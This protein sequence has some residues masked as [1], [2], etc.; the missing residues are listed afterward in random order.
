MKLIERTAQ[1]RLFKLLRRH[2]R[3]TKR[4]IIAG[5]IVFTLLIIVYFTISLLSITQSEIALARLKNSYE[6]EKIC[7]E[8]CY[9]YRL[10]QEELVIASINRNSSKIEK[11]LEKYWFKADLNP[12][13][14]L[15]IV[16]LLALRPNQK[17]MPDYLSLYLT[18][19][20]YD[21]NVAREIIKRYDLSLGAENDLVTFLINKLNSATS[22]PDK[23][24]AL[25]ILAELDDDGEIENYL[26]ILK[27]DADDEFK[28]QV[29][30]NISNIKDKGHY[31]NAEQMTSLSSLANLETTSPKLRQ[32]IVLLIGDYC[33]LFSEACLNIL[34]EIYTNESLDAISRAFSVE[35]INRLSNQ[36]YELPL[37]S[38][39]EWSNYYN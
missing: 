29:L 33:S 11:R 36:A 39:S 24:S 35:T 17:T 4:K 15:E 38:E 2:L 3:T 14:R 23:I 7:H 20:M 27:I 8:E 28:I 21:D 26:N 6:S 31:F 34:S 22:S 1:S 32:N 16:K 9:L 18:S 19:D 10:G 12:E 25:K 13:F 30:K 37:V 5:L